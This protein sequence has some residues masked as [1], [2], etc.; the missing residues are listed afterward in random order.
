[1]TKTFTITA[2]ATALIFASAPAFAASYTLT[3]PEAPQLVQKVS[4]I[5]DAQHLPG[6]RVK[7]S[8]GRDVGFVQYVVDA[9][10]LRIQFS[11]GDVRNVPASQLTVKEGFRRSEGGKEHEV[12]IRGY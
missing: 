5:T 3:A 2:A 9:N 8:G 6:A 7:A 4:F 10:T 11:N 1:M 12:L